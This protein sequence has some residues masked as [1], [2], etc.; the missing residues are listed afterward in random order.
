MPELPVSEEAAT[1]HTVFLYDD[2]GAPDAD[3]RGIASYLEQAIG[4]EALVAGDV[5]SRLAE[6]APQ[7]AAD[8]NAATGRQA[9]AA[10][11][12]KRAK[13]SN[14]TEAEDGAAGRAEVNLNAEAAQRAAGTNRPGRFGSIKDAAQAM[15]ATRVHNLMRRDSFEPPLPAEVDFIA[16]QLSRLS[17]RKFGHLYDA[18]AAMS[19]YRDLLP[20]QNNPAVV[21]TYQIMATWDEGDLK[22]HA[23]VLVAGSP[24]IISIP[25]VVLAPARPREYYMYQAGARAAGMSEEEIDARMRDTIGDRYVTHGD[26]RIPEILKGYALQAVAYWVF[27]E[28]F[29]DDPDCRLFNAHWQ[30][31]MLR[32]QLDGPY[33]FCPRHEEM[34]RG[35]PHLP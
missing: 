20:A 6:A 14:G 13:Q 18:M 15:A 17:P 1:S 27:G 33:E 31:E 8:P 11:A 19:V 25:G 23:R 3:L 29:C 24:S 30:E 26:T 7:P 34:L 4:I 10:G 9:D 16:R 35:G 12:A 2:G 22:Y 28:G 5:T 21:F 32:A